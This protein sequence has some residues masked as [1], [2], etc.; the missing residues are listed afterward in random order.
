MKP[1][2][3]EEENVREAE[4]AAMPDGTIDHKAWWRHRNLRTMNLL[5]VFPLLSIFTLGYVR[6]FF[7]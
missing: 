1:D 3:I 2:V 6:M 4:I 5:L 7:A